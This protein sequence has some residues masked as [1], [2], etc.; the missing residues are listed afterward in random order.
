[1]EFD[2]TTFVLEIINFLVLV[3]I[4]KRFLY[5]PLLRVVAQRRDSIEQAMAEAKRIHAE[6]TALHQ[7]H[8]A[9]LELW[10]EE[11]DSARARLV[12]EIAAE[13][14]RLLAELDAGIAAERDKRRILEQRELQ[15]W[16]RTVETEGI[17]QGATFAARLFSRLA[18]PEVEVKLFEVLLADLG[19][20]PQEER[21]ALAEAAAS[22]SQIR[23]ESAFP[24]DEARRARFER[25]FA[26]V[27]G[28]A[29]P[30]SYRENPELLAG[31]QVRVGPWVLH[32]NL[33][34]EL[35][36]FSRV[37]RHAD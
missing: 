10:E 37:R 26:E 4:L 1:M 29:L 17:Q 3:W 30:A 21:R 19:E 23:V 9:Q 6:A 35:K 2:W 5:R 27:A 36:F 28:R 11:K 7:Q 14:K 8:V 12:E 18:S 25:A 20:L 31:C 33:R 13:R 15:E 22:E 32:A 24:L 34:D 16:K